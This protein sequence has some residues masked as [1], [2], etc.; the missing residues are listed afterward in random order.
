MHLPDPR[1]G[2][3]RLPQQV[4]RRQRRLRRPRP[5]KKIHLDPLRQI[6]EVNTLNLTASQTFT[7]NRCEQFGAPRQINRRPSALGIVIRINMDQDIQDRR[8]SRQNSSPGSLR[9]ALLS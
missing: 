6:V 2:Q 4:D 3:K 9:N 7:C 1:T 5:Q 8:M